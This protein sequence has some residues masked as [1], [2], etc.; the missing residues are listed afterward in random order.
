VK[1]SVIRASYLTKMFGDE[2]AVQDISFDLPRDSIFGYI[3]SSGS[4]R[5]TTAR[6]LTGVYTPTAGDVSVLDRNPANFSQGERAHLQPNSV[7]ASQDIEK[8][9]QSVGSQLVNA[10][11]TANVDEALN[12]LRLGQV[13]MVI[14]EPADALNTIKNNRQ[15]VF[16]LYHQEIDPVR[17]TYVT[18]LG[19]LH[20]GA[21]N[22]QA[23]RGFAMQGQRRIR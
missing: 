22:Q 4:G 19:W 15:V 2:F 13:D 12:C 3:G 6:L 21:V 23:L 9:V 8:Y 5:T 10:G 11:A 17:V 16:T 20:V 18:Y 1:D 14:V 7:I